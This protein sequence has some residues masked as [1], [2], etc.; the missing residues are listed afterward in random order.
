MNKR[1]WIL[2]GACVCVLTAS[3]ALAASGGNEAAAWKDF[4]WRV[5]NLVLFVGIIYK[6]AGKRIK[7]FFSGR[8]DSIRNELQEL[9][10][11]KA[12][13]AKELQRVEDSI[14][15]LEQERQAILDEAQKQGEAARQAI[16]AKAN[17][18]AEKIQEQARLKAEQE[19]QFMLDNLRA[20]MADK[21]IESAEKM[22]SDKLTKKEQEKLVDKYL[23]KVVLN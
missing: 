22:L 12:N 16:L 9:E 18:D 11:R 15:G 7:E 1:C 21:I 8:K 6:L 4:M 10:N 17:E 3:Q 20:E 14:A 19:A 23:T 5:L 13:A 2:L